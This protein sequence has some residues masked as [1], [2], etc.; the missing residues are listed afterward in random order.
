LVDIDGTEKEMS[1]PELLVLKNDIIPK[2]EQFIRAIPT[3]AEGVSVHTTGNGSIGYRDIKKIE[4]KKESITDKGIKMEEVV[5]IGYKVDET[6][7]Y[8]VLQRDSWNEIDRIH[9]F[10]QRVKQAINEAN[11]T[12][13]I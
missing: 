4:K 13:L 3:R 6:T 1:V 8:G 12:P 10:A 11:K 5:V 2:L 7:D 9:D